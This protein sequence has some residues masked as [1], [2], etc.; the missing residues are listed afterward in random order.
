MQNPKLKAGKEAARKR[1]EAPKEHPDFS[2][3]EKALP[4]FIS[5]KWPQWSDYV[6]IT[7]RTMANLDSLGQGPA[8]KLMIGNTAAYPRH[9]LI[10]W[11]KERSFRVK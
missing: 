3:F 5:R 10:E 8:E 9:A 6:P 7:P 11:L 1:R 4:P 2:E